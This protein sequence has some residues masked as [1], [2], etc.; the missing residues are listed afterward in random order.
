MAAVIEE[1]IFQ[2]DEENPFL[3]M[4]EHPMTEMVKT[5]LPEEIDSAEG[6]SGEELL[7]TLREMTQVERRF[8]SAQTYYAEACQRFSL[9]T[10][11]LA[12]FKQE[13]Q[14]E[15]SRR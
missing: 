13:W 10:Q 11:K 12:S 8:R 5:R 4:P 6:E 3:Q 9:L 14:Q 7:R 1:T 15:D 2:Q